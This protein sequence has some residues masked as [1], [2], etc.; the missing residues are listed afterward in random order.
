MNKLAY[1]RE[2]KKF[3]GKYEVIDMLENVIPCYNLA[4]AR[5]IVKRINEEKK[6]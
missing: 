3:Y 6:C 5:S 2:S 1:I 4:T